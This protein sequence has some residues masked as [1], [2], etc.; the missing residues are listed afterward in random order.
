ME[1]TI[2]IPSNRVDL[3]ATIHF[4]N[5]RMENGKFPLV[6]I[7]HGFIGNRMGVNRLFVKA[8]REFASQGFAVLRFDYEG[9]G[10][11]LGEYG[12]YEFGRFI[13]QTKDV[14]E[15]ASNIENVDED[16]IILV[17]HSLGGAVAAL[18]ACTEDRIKKLVMWSAVGHPFHDIVRIVGHEEYQKSLSHSFVDHEGYALTSHF[19]ESLTHYS[20]LEAAKSFTGDVFLAHGTDDQEI[21]VDYCALYHHAFKRGESKSCVKEVIARA[22]HTFSS[23]EGSAHLF[24]ST[25]QWLLMHTDSH[26]REDHKMT[27]R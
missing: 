2:K 17:G 19:F 20:P 1:K 12:S 9:C 7:C 24:R 22:D 11:S 13:Q 14:I 3:A 16:Q 18:T 26:V 25:L 27:Q 15:F 8:A 6:I 21:P 5:K 10:E 4:P 23:L